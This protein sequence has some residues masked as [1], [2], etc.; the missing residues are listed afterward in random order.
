MTKVIPLL[1]GMG[2][3]LGA[4]TVDTGYAAPTYPYAYGDPVYGSLD[5][6]YGGWGGWH[7]DHGHWAHGGGHGFAGHASAGGHGG[8]G[9]G[10]GHG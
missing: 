5:F 3:L 4:C 2:F 7:H 1:M 8:H 10:H 9:G 6:D